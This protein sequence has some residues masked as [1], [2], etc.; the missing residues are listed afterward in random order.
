MAGERRFDGPIEVGQKFIWEPGKDDVTEII[1][2][3]TVK[4]PNRDGDIWIETVNTFGVHALNSEDRFREAVVPYHE[5][6]PTQRK[7]QPVT[8]PYRETL[9]Y[10]EFR[11]LAED[12]QP[13]AEHFYV[14]AHSLVNDLPETE[15]TKLFLQN[16][17]YAKD[18]A[19]RS[20]LSLRGA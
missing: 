16:L 4:A 7:E 3:V 2:V 6:E 5:P 9:T 17:L 19:V 11:H 15:Q 13:I 18:C 1:T 10:F 8:G 12:L 14:L 20:Q